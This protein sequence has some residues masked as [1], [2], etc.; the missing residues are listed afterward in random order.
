MN[1]NVKGKYPITKSDTLKVK[2]INVYDLLQKVTNKKHKC[3]NKTIQKCA[4]NLK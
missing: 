1:W 4:Y 3:A 2:K